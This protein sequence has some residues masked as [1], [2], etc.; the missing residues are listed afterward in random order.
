MFTHFYKES[1]RKTVVAFG[2]LFNNIVISRKNADGTEKERIRVPI[3]YGPKE[4]FLARINET[5]GISDDSKVITLPRLGFE[6]TN[7]TYDPSRKRNSLTKRL[8]AHGSTA[9]SVQYTYAEVPYDIGFALYGISRTMEDALQITEQIIPYFTPDFT[10]TMKFNDIDTNVDVPFV[11]NNVGIEEDYLGD[12]D[13]RRNITMNYSF[14]AKSY[15]YQRTRT[16]API[17]TV[18]FKYFSLEGDNWRSADG[19]TGATGAQERRIYGASGSANYDNYGYTTDID[20]TKF[21]IG[22]TG[23]SGEGLYTTGAT[24]D[25]S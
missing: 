11:L 1:V 16:K 12:F 23:P 14:V 10:V 3:A 5:S 18:D 4:K 13:S 9:D 17:R 22:S 24:F 25:G 6:I 15:V 19:S 7:F 20:I 8:A 21:S 2:S